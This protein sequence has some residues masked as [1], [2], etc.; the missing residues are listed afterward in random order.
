MWDTFWLI[1]KR[2]LLLAVRSRSEIFTTVFFFVLVI[3]LFPL[4]IT[5]DLKVLKMIAAGVFWV[6]AL[7]ASMLALERLFNIDFNDGTLAQMLLSP[8]NMIMII[9]AKTGAHWLISALPLILITPILGLQYDL[10]NQTIIILTLSLL[11]G[12]PSLSLIGSIGAALTLGLRGGGILIS[13]LILPL[14]IPVLIFGAGAVEAH[15]SGLGSA[16]HL[17]MLSAV[18]LFALVLS[19]IATYF[20]LKISLEQ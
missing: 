15:T 11:L 16:G 1:F 8:A 3:S 13:L 10:D 14:C 9:L 6:A 20:S 2:D 19:P 4:A 18:T 17:Y 12:T 5:P 7:L